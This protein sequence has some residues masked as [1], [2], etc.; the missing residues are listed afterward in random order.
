ML[1]NEYYLREAA[2]SEMNGEVA[3]NSFKVHPNL[4]MDSLAFL[5]KVMGDK[6][7]VIHSPMQH[8]RELERK[9]LPNDVYLGSTWTTADEEHQK[10][11]ESGY[12]F[13]STKLFNRAVEVGS[14]NSW[15]TWR[16]QRDKEINEIAEKIEMPT[17]SPIRWSLNK[18]QIFDKE[19]KNIIFEH[20][21]IANI[22]I[23]NGKKLTGEETV[24][25]NWF[26]HRDIGGAP[27]VT[28]NLDALSSYLTLMEWVI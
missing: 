20:D 5:A 26:Y 8:M 25:F 4:A 15:M 28:V 19:W 12:P 21:R 11:R 7:Y 18:V 10:M 16:E 14:E 23:V 13:E 24:R 17:V 22:I 6:I 9:A 2:K 1:T 3:E 27:G